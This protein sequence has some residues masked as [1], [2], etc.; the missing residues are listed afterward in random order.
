MDRLFSANYL[1]ST[2]V[3]GASAS[4]SS[5][6]SDPF[7]AFDGQVG[8]GH[9]WISDN[10]SPANWLKIDLG[11][12]TTVL[13]VGSP[14]W[15][16]SASSF[17]SGCDPFLAFDR[18][19]GGGHQWISNNGSPVNWL[20][21]DLGSG[22]SSTL[23]SYG[24]TC[25]DVGRVPKDWTLEGSNDDSTWDTL[26]TVTNATGW[27]SGETR[28]FTPAVAT[29]AYRYFRLNVTANN[30]DGS[31][32]QVEELALYTG[33][34]VPNIATSYGITSPG[35]TRA[36]KDWTLEGSNDDSTWDT[37]DTVTNATGWGSN[38]TR[39][40]TPAVATTAYRYFRLNITANNGDGSFT[41]VEELALYN[42]ATSTTTLT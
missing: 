37:L 14:V 38:E 2:G 10:G 15:V 25:G 22:N 39:T 42:A 33:E 1:R 27:A 28:T 8:G 21:F 36:P 19:V 5:Y 18:Q 40:F 23:G 29:T 16:A 31:Y 34:T 9:E 41:Q 3:L 32:T 24:L 35:S 12:T 17:F 6:H 4:S 26:D 30:G 7:L 20:E 13:R 11:S